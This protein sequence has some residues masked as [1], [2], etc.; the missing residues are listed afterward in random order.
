[1]RAVEVDQA[2]K[3]LDAGPA[4]G[5]P[6]VHHDDFAFMGGDEVLNAVV[7]EDAQLDGVGG[8]GLRLRCGA[9]LLRAG[10]GGLRTGLRARVGCRGLLATASDEAEGEKGE[11][12]QG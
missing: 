1:V 8:L 7:V 10:G 4:G 3:L 12:E 11:S 6:D 9:R 2:G 5:G